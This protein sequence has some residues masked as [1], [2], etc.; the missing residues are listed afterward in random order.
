[1]WMIL[2]QRTF[3]TELRLHHCYNG[4]VLSIDD[5]AQFSTDCSHFESLF[6]IQ[7]K[8][9]SLHLTTEENCT[10]AAF[11]VMSAGTHN[12]AGCHSVTRSNCSFYQLFSPCAAFLLLIIHICFHAVSDV[13]DM[14][15]HEQ[16]FN[17]KWPIAVHN[18]VIII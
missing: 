13:Q 8:L 9:Q 5:L 3:N 11:T 10:L 14:T 16:K 7:S 15:S 2:S 12:I 4:T 18:Y 1:M 17:T 6:E